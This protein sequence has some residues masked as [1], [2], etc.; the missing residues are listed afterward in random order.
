MLAGKQFGSYGTHLQANQVNR[1]HYGRR[2][3][4]ALPR[5][6]GGMIGC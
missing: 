5:G 1:G 3:Q 4:M 2:G 6:Q